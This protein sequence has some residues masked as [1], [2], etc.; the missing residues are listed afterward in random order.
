MTPGELRGMATQLAVAQAGE[1]AWAAPV[2]EA[3]IEIEV[4]L[5]G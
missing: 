1:V 2:A 3:L 4:A 5:V